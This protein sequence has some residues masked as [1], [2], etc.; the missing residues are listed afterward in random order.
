MEIKRMPK[1]RKNKAEGRDGM[2]YRDHIKKAKEKGQLPKDYRIPHV[3]AGFC[4][5]YDL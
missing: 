3:G 4:S 2:S 1:R 5:Q